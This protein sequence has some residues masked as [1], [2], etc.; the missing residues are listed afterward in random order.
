MKRT[1]KIVLTLLLALTLAVGAAI[2]S[3][4][5]LRSFSQR[6]QDFKSVMS[7]FLPIKKQG[8]HSNKGIIYGYEFINDGKEAAI[9]FVSTFTKTRQAFGKTIT[10]PKHI[11]GR[12]VTELN[13]IV[14]PAEGTERMLKAVKDKEIILSKY[15]ARVNG[16]AL[17]GDTMAGDGP[18]KVV[19]ETGID[20][21]GNTL[22]QK[23][24]PKKPIF[25]ILSWMSDCWRLVFFVW[26]Y[27]LLFIMAYILP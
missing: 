18:T 16:N 4:A 23:S 20:T 27:P 2:P 17:E 15:L 21:N 5:A 11:W 9:T 26:F 6:G 3:A 25:N 13:G 24:A 7:M 8:W 10:L 1:A 12:P 19:A 22:L 14:P